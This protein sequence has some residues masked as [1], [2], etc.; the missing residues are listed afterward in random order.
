MFTIMRHTIDSGRAKRV[1]PIVDYADNLN[2][3][4]VSCI[5]I[6]NCRISG[7]ATVHFL[8]D[9]VVIVY[10]FNRGLRRL[11]DYNAGAFNP[12][13]PV[14]LTPLLVTGLMMIPFVVRYNTLPKSTRRSLRVFS[15]P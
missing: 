8:V 6:V 12:F 10:V 5:I 3:G 11:L 2:Y 15:S 4:L 14:S 13:S 7:S 9:Y 1:V